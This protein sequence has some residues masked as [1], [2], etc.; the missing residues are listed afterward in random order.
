MKRVRLN[1][2][3][4]VYDVQNATYSSQGAPCLVRDLFTLLN[5]R[6]KVHISVWTI[7]KYPKRYSWYL[8]DSGDTFLPLKLDNV[9]SLM[10]RLC[11]TQKSYIK[12]T[13]LVS[14]TNSKA[15]ISG[16]CMISGTHYENVFYVG[17]KLSFFSFLDITWYQKAR[18]ESSYY[19]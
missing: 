19:M 18:E 15:V 3:F 17:N 5:T 2:N 8:S 1:W 10:L 12:S 4:I 13:S 7:R 16:Q 9:K 14:N 6:V 11:G